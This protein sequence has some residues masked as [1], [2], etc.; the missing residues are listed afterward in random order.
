MSQVPPGESVPKEERLATLYAYQILGTPHEKEFD[1]LA[2]L[3]AQICGAPA[4]AITFLDDER[5]WFKSCLGIELEETPRSVAFCDYTIRGTEPFVVT[6]ARQDPRFADSPLVV[7]PPHLRA[8]LGLPLIVANGAALGALTVL[9]H[10]PREWTSEQI[11]AVKILANQTVNLLE[12]RLL[13]REQT[14]LLRTQAANETSLRASE[15]QYRLLFT[16]NPHPMWV[17]DSETLRFV[18]VNDA[19]IRHYGYT[20]DQ[21]LAMTIHDIRPADDV[22]RL[23][24]RLATLS[25]GPSFGTWRHR[26][27]DGSVIDVEISSD[28]IVY[29]GRAARLVLAVDITQRR[30][31]EKRLRQQAAL[32]DIANDAITVR[33][34]DDRITFWNPSAE[35]LYGWRAEEALGQSVLDLLH[36]DKEAFAA[37]RAKLMEEGAWTGQIRKR[38]RAGGE[39]TV[40]GSWTLVYDETGA[41]AAVLAI[42][43]DVT[44]R[45]KLQAQILRAQ[46]MESIGTLAGGIAH[47]L[48]N[49]LAP[50]LLAVGMLRRQIAGQKEQ[51]ML[52][53]LEQNAQ[54]GAELVRQVLTFARGAESDRTEVNL[55]QS[56][57]ELER[58]IRDTFDRRIRVTT[59]VDPDIWPVMG[60]PTQIHQILLNLCVNA[61][62]AMP[63]GGH[64]E[65]EAHNRL[66][67]EQYASMNPQAEP[68]RYVQLTVADSGMG[69][70]PNIRERIFDPFFT[71]K[72]VGQG[73]GLGLSTVQALVKSHGGFVTLYS[74]EGQGTVFHIYLPAADTDAAAPPHP[75]DADLVHGQNQLILVVDDESAVRTVVQQTLENFGYRVITAE[76]GATAL[77]LYVQHAAEVAL[78]LTDMMMPIM[79]GYAFIQALRKVNPD[80]KVI[81]ASGLP[82]NGMAAKIAAAGVKHFLHKPYTAE[83]MLTKLA[84]VLHQDEPPA[85]Q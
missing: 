20:R 53:M 19:A 21:F 4:A 61:R 40:D 45:N 70:P 16:S 34:L 65:L 72:D 75:L 29:D 9:D 18:D 58:L 14:E 78:V 66:I 62:D 60:D 15:Q 39:I 49:V 2:R 24:R 44:E 69:I 63:Q 54:R 31:A 30:Q 81:S 12:L 52:D 82:A 80:V 3:A 43:T 33:D 22:P 56:I 47:D 42:N 64:L 55:T 36:V 32:L 50:I 5:Q 10:Q 1:D 79:D 37:A 27:K 76:E 23:D 26:K 35:R 68:G 25:T 17:Y 11:E 83:A 67:D 13:H 73:T 28:S 74:E 8:Y 7:H 77:S 48:N 41:P 51:H 71:T 38:N 6:D 46:R 84:E 59:T 57:S 85:A